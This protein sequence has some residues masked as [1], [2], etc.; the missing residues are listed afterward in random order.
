M[1]QRLYSI[2]D[3][4]AKSFGIPFVAISDELATRTVAST[5]MA[6][7][8][9]HTMFAFARDYELYFLG[10]VSS[11]GDLVPAEDGIKAITFLDDIV[12]SFKI[13]KGSEE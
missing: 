5:L 6:V 10:E 13:Q 4:R 8:P 12:S 9:N 7:P 11:D 3:I 1:N 2:K